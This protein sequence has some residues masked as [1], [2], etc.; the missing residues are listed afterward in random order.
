MTDNTAAAGF[1][2]VARPGQEGCSAATGECGQQRREW[3]AFIGGPDGKIVGHSDLTMIGRDTSDLFRGRPF[4]PSE[5]TAPG[6]WVE[7]GSLRVFVAGYDGDVF[8]SG[9]T[10]DE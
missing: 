2:A 5:L 3:F 8:G 10:R 9:W 1:P 6:A 7:T 4:P